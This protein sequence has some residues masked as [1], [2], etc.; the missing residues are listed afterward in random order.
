MYIKTISVNSPL[1]EMS[2]HLALFLLIQA[3]APSREDYVQLCLS[4]NTGYFMSTHV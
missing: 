2:S 4:N 3:A 1:L